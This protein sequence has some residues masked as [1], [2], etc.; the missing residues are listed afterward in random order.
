[1]K[2]LGALI[3]TQQMRHFGV[4]RRLHLAAMLDDDLQLKVSM[5]RTPEAE[6]FFQMSSMSALMK[7]G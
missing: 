1:M 2:H 4:V 6:T 3:V 7:L 5:N